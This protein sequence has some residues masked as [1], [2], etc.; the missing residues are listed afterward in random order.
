MPTFQDTT[1]DLNLTSECQGVPEAWALHLGMAFTGTVAVSGAV[2][3]LLA[4]AV[5]I[6]QARER[7]CRRLVEFTSDKILMLNLVLVDFLYCL[8]AMPSLLATYLLP[9]EYH[10]LHQGEAEKP[11]PFCKITGLLRYIMN[12]AEI[13]TISLI[14]LERC[15]G[16]LKRSHL[17]SSRQAI[18]CCV[19]VWILSTV[20][21]LAILPS[22]K[23]GFNECMFKC[24][25]LA[26]GWA[27]VLVFL[28]EGV[29]PVVILVVAYWLVIC[30]VLRQN[31]Y[32]LPVTCSVQ[33]QRKVA[34]RTRR[35]VCCLVRYM[36][37][38]SASI[39][40][41]CIYNILDTR[42]MYK[43]LGILIYCPYWSLFVA[44]TW[45]YLADDKEYCLALVELLGR[46][47]GLRKWARRRRRNYCRRKRREHPTS[48]Q[49]SPSCLV[50]HPP[51]SSFVSLMPSEGPAPIYRT[52]VD[53]LLDLLLAHPVPSSLCSSSTPPSFPSL[54][55]L[56]LLLLIPR[57]FHPGGLQ[58][59]QGLHCVLAGVRDFDIP[60]FYV[61]T[62]FRLPDLRKKT[63]NLDYSFGKL[64]GI[65]AKGLMKT[66]RLPLGIKALACWGSK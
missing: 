63:G 7:P 35:V 34:R 46:V 18:G 28:A 59:L 39:I 42:G 2:L 11:V 13:N 21:Q 40:P 47:F 31:F 15:H 30:H 60:I 4:L 17:L 27:R 50:A 25:F 49:V 57:S 43:E 65:Q 10:S 23:F 19:F 55:L 56:L 16:I 5:F 48:T 41:V 1:E 12:S 64:Q 36:G 24:D 22:L 9:V 38:Y 44:N 20:L 3:N 51:S 62:P 58:M 61:I 45:M 52:L 66:Y 37:L 33:E 53:L 14:S 29:G 6:Q 32:G 8:V 26:M 54:S